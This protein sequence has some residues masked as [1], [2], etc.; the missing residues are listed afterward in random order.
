MDISGKAAIVTGGASGLGAATARA[1]AS[2]GAK[3]AIFDM[4]VELA[5][6]VASEIGGIA[7]S[8]NVSDDSSVEA[9]FI[10]A[11]D[12]H[13]AARILVNCAGIGPAAKTVSGRGM[14]PLDKFEQVISVNLIGT[15]NCLR[16]AADDMSKMEAM[17]GGER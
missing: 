2:A 5:K 1:L 17:E 4:N 15:F 10:T 16:R 7:V 3:V 13:G 6:E 8:V 11:R 14:H 12:A 9:A